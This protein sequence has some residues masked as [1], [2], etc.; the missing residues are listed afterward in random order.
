MLKN[1]LRSKDTSLIVPANR[2]GIV[3]PGRRDMKRNFVTGLSTPLCRLSPTDFFDLEMATKGVHIFGGIGSGKTSGPGRFLSE[4]YLRNGFGFCVTC[5]KPG[6]V[7]WWVRRAERTNRLNSLVILD[8]SQCF[9][10]CDYGVQ[11]YGMDGI[12]VVVDGMVR[13]LDSARNITSQG[14]QSAG[15]PLWIDGPPLA[16]RHSVQILYAA[17]GR[18]TF[19]DLERFLNTAPKTSAQLKDK[20]FLASCFMA[21]MMIRANEDPCVPISEKEFLQCSRFWSENWI[22]IPEKIR[23]SF[24]ISLS[25]AFDRFRHGRLE[26]MT[27]GRTTVYP[28]LSLGGAVI[29]LA[30]P[31]VTFGTDAVIFQQLFKYFWQKAILSRNG[32]DPIHRERPQCLFSDEAQDMVSDFDATDWQNLCRDS[33]ACS[34]FLSQSLPN[35]VSK[36]GRDKT[37]ALVSKFGNQVFTANNCPLTN[38]YAIKLLGREVKRRNNASMGTSQSFTC[39]MSEGYSESTSSSYSSGSSTSNSPT[40][41]TT[42]GSNSGSSSSSTRGSNY[43]TNVGRGTSHSSNFGY[44]EAMENAMEHGDFASFMTGGPQNGNVVSG[45]WHKTGRPFNATGRNYIPVRFTQQ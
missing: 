6:D 45:I 15:E 28:E 32:M 40:G 29:L 23:G 12:S 27:S 31:T 16:L 2:G 4:L 10:F 34:V 39:G 5:T 1:W 41:G 8:Q 42:T 44:S 30:V 33:L 26:R 19:D 18:I 25:A 7:E 3:V 37:D 21:Q 36:I 43:G 24:L 35:Y 14:H 38:E 13:V 20:S 9:N 22:G 11:K 17:K